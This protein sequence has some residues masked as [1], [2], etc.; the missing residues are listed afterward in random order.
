MDSVD[1]TCD[2]RVHT[3]TVLLM[4]FE[5]WNLYHQLGEFLNIYVS[6]LVC[7]HVLSGF[8]SNKLSADHGLSKKKAIVAQSNSNHVP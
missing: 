3:P 5:E 4:R 2:I 6:L 7:L 8:R 1:G